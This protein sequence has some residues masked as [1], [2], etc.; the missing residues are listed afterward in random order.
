MQQI[1]LP[2]GQRYGDA[3][4]ESQ[5]TERELTEDEAVLDLID[6]DFEKGL[7]SLRELVKQEQVGKVQLTFE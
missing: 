7:L 1:S 6:K 3:L 4:M 5:Q 2:E